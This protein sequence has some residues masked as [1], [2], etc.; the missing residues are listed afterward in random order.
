MCNQKTGVSVQVGKSQYLQSREEWNS[1]RENN[2]TDCSSLWRE[3]AETDKTDK[4][5]PSGH[6]RKKDMGG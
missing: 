5:K 4:Y 2:S 1:V 6:F 3:E